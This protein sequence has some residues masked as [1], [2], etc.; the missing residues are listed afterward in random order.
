MV[1]VV[2]DRPIELTEAP[3][4]P[5]TE[6]VIWLESD[7]PV[8]AAVAETPA[9]GQLSDEEIPEPYRRAP[10][11]RDSSRSPARVASRASPEAP[12][13]SARTATRPVES[14]P[15]ARRP[16]PDHPTQV[17]EPSAWVV[18]PGGRLRSW[19]ARHR[20]L[21]VLLG[22][23]LV[24]GLTVGY[25]LWLQRWE[26]LPQVAEINWKE[27]QSAFDSGHFDEAKQKLAVAA[28]AFE[29]LGIIDERGTQSRQLAEE[30]AILAD[31]CQLKL[32]ELIEE[33]ARFQPVE[34]WP[35]RFATLYKGQSV[36]FD[37]T[38]SALPTDSLSGSYEIDHRILVGR[39]PV[40]SRQGRIDLQGFQLFETLKPQVG[41]S[42]IF[43]A[44]LDSLQFGDGQW[45]IRLEP[46]SG[47]LMTNFKALVQ[48][49][50]VP[51]ETA[52][53]AR[54]DP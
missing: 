45:I 51:S 15:D 49:E 42:K 13:H 28:T 23:G 22:M 54:E 38:I 3:P 36:V 35:Q 30:A 8:E 41:E 9:R 1:K 48:A 50:W 19:V 26:K 18:E 2:E 52:A 21:L 44:R 5:E 47:I 6:D 40:P 4:Q 12:E 14:H 31:R 33:A 29:R 25:R 11:A 53:S 39:G 17:E 24:V 32:D 20:I 34:E 10:E 43:G 27:G 7:E 46:N 16:R 37:T